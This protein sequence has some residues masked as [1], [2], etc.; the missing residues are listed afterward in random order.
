MEPLPRYP[1]ERRPFDHP[2]GYCFAHRDLE[3]LFSTYK[4]WKKLIHFGKYIA[5]WFYYAPQFLCPNLGKNTL[6]L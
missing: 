3:V 2:F 1:G 4:P 5:R 6:L